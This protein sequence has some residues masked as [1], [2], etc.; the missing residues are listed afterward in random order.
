MDL[1]FWTQ[2]W[3]LISGAP[4]LVIGGAIVIAMAVWA[5]VSWAYRRQMD[6]LKAES[7]AWEAR[8]SLAHDREAVVSQKRN[9]L[10]ATVQLLNNQITAKAATDEIAATTQ[11]VTMIARELASANSALSEAL[12]PVSVADGGRVPLTL[13]SEDR[14]PGK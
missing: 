7:G 13:S 3:P 9:E 10:E 1:T 5:L 14:P 12:I 4:H 2:E 8:L 6:G 11:S